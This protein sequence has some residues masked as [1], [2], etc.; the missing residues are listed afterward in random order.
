MPRLVANFV[1]IAVGLAACSLGA[2]GGGDESAR[3][4]NQEVVAATCADGSVV[5]VDRVESGDRRDV[6]S[7]LDDREDDRF[8][9]PLIDPD[10]IRS[11]GPPP[12]GIPP[13]DDPKFVRQ[14]SVDWLTA[15]E[16]VLD[17]QIG[18]DARAYPLRIMTWHEIVNDT[19]DGV[20][21]TISYC[22]LCNSAIAYDRRVDGDVLDFGTSGQ[23]LRSSL[24]MYDRQTES[25]W[26]HFTATAVVGSLTG[27][28]LE[29]FPVQTISFD[30]FR[31]AHPDGLVL[32]Q[33]TGHSRDYGR[34]PYSGYDDPSASPFLFDG[35]ADDTLPPMTRVIGVERRGQA[36]ALL[37]DRLLDQRV[38][39]F[40]IGGE[41]LVA[42]VKPGTASALDASSIPD[43]RD[44]GASGVFVPE[45]DARALTF[46]ADGETFR[47]DETGSTWNVLGHAVAGPLEGRRLE[48]VTHLDTF[49][50]AW[51]AFQPET[52]VA[53]Q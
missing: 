1:L 23:L 32:S 17:L 36:V 10:E 14:C 20:P 51:S 2:D 26:S 11:G 47:D 16:P 13:I 28:A 29:T 40:E 53:R 39:T 21:V 9:D 6:P 45:V 35:D 49:W 41:T 52:E 27:T 38:T 4:V 31:G 8:P 22:P 18:D 12:D 42:W 24:V 7:A 50:F 25:L 19:I 43:G 15:S 33:D 3:G 37:L 48:A 46:R 44:V 34:N 30:D 5:A